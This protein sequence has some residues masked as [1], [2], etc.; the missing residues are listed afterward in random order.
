M[1]M[2][3]L[4]DLLTEGEDPMAPVETPAEKPVDTRSH[5][6]NGGMNIRYADFR[7][8]GYSL[9]VGSSV[10]VVTPGGIGYR[11]RT[12]F[13]RVMSETPL[14]VTLKDGRR[15]MKSTGEAVGGSRTKVDTPAKIV[16][17]TVK[18]GQLPHPAQLPKAR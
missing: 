10:K 17:A 18:Q 8:L 3:S 1:K 13:I 2:R 5:L 11:G 14:Q 9:E 15:F 6:P 4:I 16:A 12:D 7:N